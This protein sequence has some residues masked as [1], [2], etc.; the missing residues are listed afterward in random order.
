M[1]CSCIIQRERSGK[2]I[3]SS[4]KRGAEVFVEIERVH[5]GVWI[6]D[7]GVRKGLTIHRGRR[8]DHRRGMNWWF[9]R[10]GRRR[11]GVR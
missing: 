7:I 8:T 9:R 5:R 3:K 10:R 2:C 4:G 6:E 11:R 1:V